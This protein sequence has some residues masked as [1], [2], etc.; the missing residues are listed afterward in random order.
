[1]RRPVDIYD[2]IVGTIILIL[3]V[4]GIGVIGWLSIALSR[5]VFWWLASH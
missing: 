2:A 3:I 4:C 5:A 1:M